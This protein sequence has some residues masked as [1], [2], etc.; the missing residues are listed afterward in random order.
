MASGQLPRTS[1]VGLDATVLLFALIAS[2]VTGVLFG[3][4]P[5]LRAR[6][7]DLQAALREAGAAWF[8][9]DSDCAPGSSSSK[10][11]WPLS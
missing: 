5:A 1:E 3:L 7:T 6:G 9:A 10:W 8:G 2:I 11:H 4:A